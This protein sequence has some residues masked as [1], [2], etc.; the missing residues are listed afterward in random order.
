MLL[1]YRKMTEIFR[2]AC[3]PS[4]AEST[5][6]NACR[7]QSATPILPEHRLMLPSSASTT[8]VRSNVASLWEL[9]TKGLE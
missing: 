8:Y 3:L 5:G 9:D 6:F 2:S 7:S 1:K 4:S